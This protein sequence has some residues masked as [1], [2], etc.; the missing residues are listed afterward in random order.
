[1][2]V[3][4]RAGRAGR[5]LAGGPALALH[6]VGHSAGAIFHSHLLPE[7][8][9]RNVGVASLSLLA[10][11]VRVDRFAQS[12]QPLCAGGQI[13][14]L[15]LYTMS[16]EAELADTVGPYLKSL[17]YLVSR[18]CEPRQPTPILG[19]QESLDADP[20]LGAWLAGNATVQYS[21]P[22]TS[23]PTRCA[24]PSRTATS[25]TTVTRSARCSAASRASRTQPARAATTFRRRRPRARARRR[26]ARSSRRARRRARGGRAARGRRR[27]LCVGIDRYAQR[28]LAGCVADARRWAEA[29]GELA[30]AVT[31]L[32]DEA[33][34]RAA[35]LGA[36]EAMIGDARAGDLLVFQYSGHGTQVED[37]T[38]TRATATTRRSFRSTT[39]PGTCCSTTTSRASRRAC[40]R[41]SC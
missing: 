28:P 1:V 32:H 22:R 18:A 33:A 31:T 11:A 3:R 30:F 7:L 15:H 14:A 20:A 38:P 6:A 10:P 13:G 17:L 5:E 35:M 24:R 12:L 39:R 29:L 36:L 37:S 40:R 34:T 21:L 19:L 2:A 41:A 4:Q 16:E 8:A 25:T 27:A 9:A 23:R 26:C